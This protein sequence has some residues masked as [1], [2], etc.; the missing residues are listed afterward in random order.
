MNVATGRITVRTQTAGGALPVE[1]S[2]VRITGAMEENQDVEFS[3]ITDEDGVTEK[4]SLPTASI[5]LSEIPNPSKAPFYSYNLEITND[6]YY[7][8]RVFN[9]PIFEGVDTTLP[10]NMIPTE[11]NGNDLAKDNLNTEIFE[12][13]EVI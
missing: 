11:P 4:I 12:H 10:V 2:I 9:L 7:T 5:A 8:K 3:L 6:G 1:N 13:L